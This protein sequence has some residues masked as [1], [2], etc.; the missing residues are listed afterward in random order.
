M[1]ASKTSPPGAPARK[2]APPP[3]AVP[4]PAVLT[5]LRDP[6]PFIAKLKERKLAR[7]D[8]TAERNVWD[9]VTLAWCLVALERWADA[10]SIC[11]ALAK[12]VDFTL[13][14]KY[15]GVWVPA[16]EG[17]VLGIWLAQRRGDKRRAAE[18]TAVAGAIPG[19]VAK[20]RQ[21]ADAIKNESQAKISEARLE[22]QRDRALALLQAHPL[23]WLTAELT[24]PITDLPRDLLERQLDEAIEALR[25]IIARPR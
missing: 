15:P 3:R 12:K 2:T 7:I 4:V 5:R 1:A 16:Y 25:S 14:G 11:E 22:G 19:R 9:Q 13:Q 21:R 17:V 18:L 23:E 10:A 8:Y 6:H 20:P 24:M